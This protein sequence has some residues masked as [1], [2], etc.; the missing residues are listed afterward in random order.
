MNKAIFINKD[1]T[2]IK[3]VPNN[4]NPKF[5][6][7]NE[8]VVEGLKLLQARG[9]YLILITNQEG[10]AYGYFK[11]QALLG[12]IYRVEEL[13]KFKGVYLDGHML[14]PHHPNGK[15]RKYAVD[16]DCRSPK[17]GLLINAAKKYNLDL[18]NSWI[19]GNLPE[20]IEAGNLAGCQTVLIQTETELDSE[21]LKEDVKKPQGIFV[22]ITKAA[23]FI[24]EHSQ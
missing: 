1:G 19:L 15:V 11:E 12:A 18:E 23:E 3:E 2:L 5:V 8:G 4:V 14:C 6:T 21:I 10:I 9:Y 17:P 13:L 22:D 16:C 24:V 7:L 20:D